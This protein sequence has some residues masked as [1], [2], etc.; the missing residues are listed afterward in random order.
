[1]IKTVVFRI[2]Y[3]LKGSYVQSSYMLA[4]IFPYS[5]IVYLIKSLH[6]S[7]GKAC[8]FLN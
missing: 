5:E 2:G 3:K 1:M 6:I 8:V 4:I 7:F